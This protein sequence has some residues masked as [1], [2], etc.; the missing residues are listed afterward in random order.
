MSY[1]FERFAFPKTL[2]LVDSVHKTRKEPASTRTTSHLFES[3]APLRI[4]PVYT[5]GLSLSKTDLSG[6][7]GPDFVLTVR[8]STREGG[9]TETKLPEAFQTGGDYWFACAT[10]P[11]EAYWVLLQLEAVGRTGTFWRYKRLFL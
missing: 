6:E 2:D 5:L 9:K 7:I 3:S 1:L 10:L 4:S 8:F 11:R